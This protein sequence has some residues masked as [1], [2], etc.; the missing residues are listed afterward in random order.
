[1]FE[2]TELEKQQQQQQQQRRTP[3]GILNL[4]IDK[5]VTWTMYVTAG[6]LFIWTLY[7]FLDV[8]LRYVFNHPLGYSVDVTRLAMVAMVAG[9]VA[10]A[11]LK[12]GHIYVDLITENLKPKVRLG[13]F[14]FWEVVAVGIVGVMVWQ[15]ALNALHYHKISPLTDGGLPLFPGTVI[16]TY[17]FA[18]LF[19]L[20]LRDVIRHAG[21]MRKAQFGAGAWLLVLVLPVLLLVFFGLATTQT[22]S[23]ISSGTAGYYAIVFLFLAL[24]LG[25]PIYLTL[26]LISIVLMGY[27]LGMLA[28]LSIVGDGL[29]FYC[30]SYD[31]SVIPLYVLMGYLVLLGGIGERAFWAAARWVGHYRGG[32]AVAVVG[33]STALAACVGSG[34]AATVSMG[35]IAYPEMRKYKYDDGLSTGCICGGATLGPI[36]PP[37]LPMII[38]GILTQTSIGKLFI[39]GIIPG[40]VLAVLFIVWIAIA[41]RVNPS[42]GPAG[43]R[44]SWRERLGSMTS[45]GPILALFILVIGGLYAGVF[46][47]MEGGAIGAF[48]ALLISVFMRRLSWKNF[49]NSLTESVKFIGIIYLMIAGGLILTN[50][51]G[52]SGLSNA[53]GNWIASMGLSGFDVVVFLM[54]IYVIW[55]LAGDAGIIVILTVPIMFPI[56]D[57]LGVNMI[58]WGLLTLLFG[59][60]GSITPPLAVEIFMLRSIACPDVPLRT[61]FRG[62]L[63]FC[64]ATVACG[65]LVLFIPALATWLPTIMK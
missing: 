21:E 63:P 19:I 9:S 18:L 55:G 17:G 53:L 7:V 59:G 31:F 32:L 10:Y 44:A 37:S 8:L 56:L 48:G 26:I 16:L 49:M 54:F 22:I 5:L 12:H 41:V 3:V 43:P 28:G 45:F 24:F 62:I 36:I 46:T 25:Q 64:Y 2:P 50:A 47:A 52:A 38:F 40:L 1:M 14:T 13:L 4:G 23:G 30:T 42:S 27:S 35:L 33:A 39:S 57:G 20:L 6:L 15:T 11:Q 58:W 60:M 29:F 51:Y 61:M 65:L 34:T